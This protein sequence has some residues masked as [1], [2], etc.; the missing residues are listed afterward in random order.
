ME[1]DLVQTPPRAGYR[2][3]DPQSEDRRL[4]AMQLNETYNNVNIVVRD[5]ETAVASMSLRL[6]GT[7]NF[8]LFG[9]ARL[10]VT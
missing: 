2:S 6:L 1:Y 10:V 9:T 8:S 3:Y 7:T 5:G 4:Y